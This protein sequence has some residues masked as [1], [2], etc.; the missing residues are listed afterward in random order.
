MGTAFRVMDLPVSVSQWRYCPE[1]L[2]NVT[3]KWT[4]HNIEEI[5]L[6]FFFI[7]REPIVIVI[8]FLYDIQM[9][10]RFTVPYIS[11]YRKF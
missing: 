3:I 8:K 7:T 4:E 9:W 5:S 6:Y 1:V 10:E 11:T 2:Q